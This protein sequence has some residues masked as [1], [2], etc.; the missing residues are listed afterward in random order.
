MKSSKSLYFDFQATTPV[1][2]DILQKMIPFF[3]E[4]AGN[5]HS[6]DHSVGWQSSRAVSDARQNIA[7]LI[8]AD[9]DEI[10]FTSGATEANNLG[11]LGLIN[12]R[13]DKKRKRLLIST[14]EHKSILGVAR[15][16]A[17]RFGFCLD[18]VPVD[19]EG[20]VSVS[21]IK[22]LLDDDVLAVSVMAVNNEIGTIQDI[23]GLS[24]ASRDAGAIFHCD[25]AQAPVA[26]DLSHF[27]QDVDML[28]LS[29]HKMYGPQGIGV[30]YVRRN[31]H[32]RIEPLI[33]GGDQQGGLRS[34]TLPV[35]LCVGMGE[36]ANLMRSVLIQ[37][38]RAILSS[39]RDQ[40]IDAL[41]K[42]P[43]DIRLNGPT[44]PNRHP[45][46]ANILFQGFAAH[47]ILGAL[48][49]HLAAS[50]GSACTSGVTEPS[51]VLRA[52]GLNGDE[53]EAS[54]RFS[55]GFSTD[56][57]DI[58]KAIAFISNALKRLSQTSLI[59]SA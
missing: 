20:H 13:S 38:Q 43:W 18:Y 40:F 50:T 48:Q 21:A 22:D 25:A 35:P 5:P 47:D 27:A 31:L 24:E 58:D 14:I 28:S 42:L 16:F 23:K 39:R 56:D 53:A 32:D 19:K 30:L 46:N 49:P 41:K 36:A 57:D 37:E 55:L 2:D 15:V 3:T 51:H 29:A 1:N 10:V 33:Y 44:G 9:A 34:G 54:V 59:R 17:E 11:L 8:G 45:G 26:M 7:T 4:R 6:S 52:I 12:R